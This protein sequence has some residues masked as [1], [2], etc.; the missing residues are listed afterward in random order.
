MFHA[1]LSNQS[2]VRESSEIGEVS[3]VRVHCHD[4][5]AEAKE[6]FQ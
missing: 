1:I 3:D 6:V 4:R 2:R 5:A